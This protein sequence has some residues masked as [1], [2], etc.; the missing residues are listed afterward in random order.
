MD[1]KNAE[2][3]VIIVFLIIVFLIVKFI[4]IPLIKWMKRNN[5]N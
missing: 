2:W 3:I 4:A 5:R 1:P